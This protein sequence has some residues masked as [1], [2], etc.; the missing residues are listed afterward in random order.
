[1]RVIVVLILLLGTGYAYGQSTCTALT[2]AGNPC[3][4][5]VSEAF[6]MCKTHQLVYGGDG[7]PKNYCA[8]NTAAGK[9]CGNRV[10]IGSTYCYVHGSGSVKQPKEA[11]SFGVAGQCAGTTKSGARC[12]RMTKGVYCYQ[13]GG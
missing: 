3:K 4:N 11:G 6:G 2:K 10:P 8:G 1:M 12:K 7:A 9:S 5:K 13:H